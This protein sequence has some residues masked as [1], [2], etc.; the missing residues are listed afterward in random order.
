M[1]TNGARG[2]SDKE[3]KAARAR[4]EGAGKRP[5]FNSHQRAFKIEAGY[6]LRAC[7]SK[8]T[9]VP[10]H[11]P[12]LPREPPADSDTPEDSDLLQLQRAMSRIAFE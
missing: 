8:S 6:R 9:R 4:G 7:Q 12:L 5:R 10:L 11:V 2:A 1:D 3:G